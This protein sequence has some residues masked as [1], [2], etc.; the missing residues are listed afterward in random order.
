M[1]ALPSTITSTDFG[2]VCRTVVVIWGPVSIHSTR[3]TAT[4]LSANSIGISNPRPDLRSFH[5]SP[6][7]TSTISTPSTTAP[8][9]DNA[10]A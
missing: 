10:P 7:S 4:S 5:A 6:A 9:G 2:C 3:H 8:V 1:L